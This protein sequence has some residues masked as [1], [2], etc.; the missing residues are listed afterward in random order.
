MKNRTKFLPLVF[1]LAMCLSLTACGTIV[2]PYIPDDDIGGDWRVTGVVRNGGTITRDGEDTFVLVCI[3][4]ADA[5]FYYDEEDQTLFDYVE[6]LGLDI[7]YELDLTLARGLNYYTGAIFEVKARDV[8]M[9]SISGGGRY[10]N[11]TGIFGLPNVSGVGISFGAD[12]IYDVMSELSLFPEKNAESTEVLF[13][14]FG[15]EEE[16]YCLPYLRQLRREG[17]NAEIYPDAVKIQKQMKYADQ[18]NIPVV[19]MAGESEVSNKTFSVKWMKEGRQ[20][21]INAEKIIEVIKK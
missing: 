15:H 17:V 12:R 4:K 10:D 1:A 8:A 20:E 21:T 14:N 16:M 19:V 3:H 5:S 18:R 11:L 9:G 7:E 13:L 6:A 2:D